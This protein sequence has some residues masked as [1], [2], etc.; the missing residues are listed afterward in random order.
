MKKT[1]LLGLIVATIAFGG[2]SSDLEMLNQQVRDLQDKSV[3]LRT[4]NQKLNTENNSLKESN[5][6]LTDKVT[7]LENSLQAKQIEIKDLADANRKLRI[8]LQS[9]QVAKPDTIHVAAKAPAAPTLRVPTYPIT[10]VLMKD[11][12]KHD[13]HTLAVLLEFYNGSNQTLRGFVGVL[14]FHRNGVIL[15][16]TTVNVSKQINSGERISWYGAVPYDPA[17]SGNVRMAQSSASAIQVIFDAQTITAA[18]GTV[19]K[20]K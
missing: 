19:Q 7:A 16:E 10:A 11:P 13:A 1:M 14:Q 20:V 3:L 4:D 17:N 18:N 15:L 8:E 5:K 6:A 12:V 2:K 9:N